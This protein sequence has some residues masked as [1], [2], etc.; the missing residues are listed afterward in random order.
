MPITHFGDMTYFT[1]NTLCN[2][3]ICRIVL[4]EGGKVTL[5]SVE[6]GCPTCLARMERSYW[7]QHSLDNKA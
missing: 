5:A 3:Q 2:R 1:L 7:W 6:V 4:H